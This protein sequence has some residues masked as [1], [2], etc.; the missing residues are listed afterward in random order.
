MEEYKSTKSE[1]TNPRRGA[2]HEGKK[3]GLSSEL[4]VLRKRPD[5]AVNQR[6]NWKNNVSLKNPWSLILLW[7]WCGTTR[8]P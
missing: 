3:S 6:R 8:F 4:T 1:K 5:A 2:D 7:S